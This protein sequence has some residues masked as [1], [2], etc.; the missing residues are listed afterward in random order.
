MQVNV[1]QATP[2]PMDLISRCA[3]V[4][5]GKDD[6][7]HKRVKNCFNNGHM[8]VFEHA[9]ITVEVD[10]ISRAC[11]HQLVRHRLASFSQQS[12]RYTR[13]SGDDWYVKPDAYSDTEIFELHMNGC[14]RAYDVSVR[15]GI[16]PED[17]RFLLP[18]ATKTRLVMTCNVRELF[19]ILDLRTDKAAQW[20]IRELVNKIKTQAVKVDDQWAEL[21]GL[22]ESRA[23]QHEQKVQAIIEFFGAD[24][25]EELVQDA[26]KF[27]D[28]ILRR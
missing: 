3:G 27:L 13:I 12:Q 9:V 17:A 23:R 14:R 26:T 18:E 16:K 6:I 25:D 7:S 21:I 24:H 11:S 1:L 2:K 20:E 19:H 8:S 28:G 4:C 10:G 15:N 22:W 5:Y